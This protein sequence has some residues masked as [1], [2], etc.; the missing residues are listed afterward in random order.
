MRI[1]TTALILAFVT[2]PVA[3]RAPS[4]EKMLAGRTPGK[5]TSCITQSQIDQTT[6]V[7]E[8]AILYQMKGGPDYLNTPT[9]RCPALRSN[10]FI[11]SR[12]YSNQ[13]CRND[14]LQI[15]DQPS[16]INFGSCALDDFIPYPRVKRPKAQ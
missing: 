9:P 10:S 15:H 13:L 6:I 16:G 1:L 11:V 7:D 5:P 3:A 4:M 8:G 2:A 12:T 14:I